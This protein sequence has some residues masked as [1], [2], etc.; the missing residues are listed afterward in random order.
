[1]KDINFG[2][3]VID[4]PVGLT[5]HDC[6]SRLRTLLSMKQIGHGGTLDPAVTGVLPIAIGKATKLL[7]FLPSSKK[8]EGTIKL[9]IITNTDDFEGE[10]IKKQSLPTLEEKDVYECIKSFQGELKQCP[11]SFSS[12]HING[13]RA[14]KKA[15]RGEKFKLPSKQIKIHNIDLINW[16]NENGQIKINVHCSS[17]TYIRSLARDIGEKLG[18]GGTLLQ[19][20]R[21]EA[22]GFNIK[23]SI[24]LKDLEDGFPFIKSPIV[25]PIKVLSHLNNIK[26]TLEEEN[27]FWCNGRPFIISKERF[28]SKKS[29]FKSQSEFSN[30]FIL[31]INNNGSLIGIGIF[32]SEDSKI[33]PKIVFNA[34]G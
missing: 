14:Y 13:E 23:D 33:Y 18:C 9:G 25:N 28:I 5:S 32:N 20:R 4:K 12:V 24:T 16:D 8:Y 26:L 3:L 17:G 31:V 27:S 11:P 2:F 15:R 21:I 22:L 7:S 30:D 1:M 10:V 34:K 29:I 6:V 19:L